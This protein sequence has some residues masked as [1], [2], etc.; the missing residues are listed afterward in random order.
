MT[1]SLQFTAEIS[2]AILLARLDGKTLSQKLCILLFEWFESFCHYLYWTLR[3]T[4]VQKCLIK[5]TQRI[6]GTDGMSLVII[7]KIP[8]R[9]MWREWT[10]RAKDL[11]ADNDIIRVIVFVI[12]INQYPA[13]LS[14]FCCC[15]CIVEKTIYDNNN[16]VVETNRDSDNWFELFY[17]RVSTMTAI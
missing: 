8:S 12:H 5:S 17:V 9:T 3:N 10:K 6:V 2:I 7:E 13:P 11:S 1:Y 16:Y 15:M 14:L 4:V